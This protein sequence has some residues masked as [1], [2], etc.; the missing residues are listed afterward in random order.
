V[1]WVRS[2]AE[3][4]GLTLLTA[5]PLRAYGDSHPPWLAAPRSLTS[6]FSSSSDDSSTTV[7]SVSV[8]TEQLVPKFKLGYGLDARLASSRR[9]IS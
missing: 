6:P 4:R 3:L 9:I 7:V 8:A 2:T 1:W 5:L